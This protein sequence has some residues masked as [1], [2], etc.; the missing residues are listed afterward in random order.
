MRAF[1]VTSSSQVVKPFLARAGRN[2]KRE[3]G[4]LTAENRKN[5]A[6][7]TFGV[8]GLIGGMGPSAGH[9]WS[10][11]AV[12]LGCPNLTGQLVER[13]LCRFSWS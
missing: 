9:K 3:D 10:G 7:E 11:N 2:S 13:G 6:D 5:T 4:E 1:K 8:T 12:I